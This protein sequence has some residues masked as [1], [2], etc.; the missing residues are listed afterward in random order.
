M[1]P[2]ALHFDWV[3]EGGARIP[4]I[5][6]SGC[7]DFN[8]FDRMTLSEIK[9]YVPRMYRSPFPEIC[10]GKE[11]AFDWVGFEESFPEEM[12]QL[13]MRMKGF[14]SGYHTYRLRGGAY[15]L[16]HPEL[17]ALFEWDHRDVVD[18]VLELMRMQDI[19]SPLYGRTTVYDYFR[20]LRRWT[21]FEWRDTFSK[22]FSPYGGERRRERSERNSRFEVC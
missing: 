6:P 19:I 5:L 11:G 20:A 18:G 2:P 13:A 22:Y 12:A 15:R 1:R 4:M 9:S 7:F 8:R 3:D 14:M 17:V 16:S 10:I 21:E